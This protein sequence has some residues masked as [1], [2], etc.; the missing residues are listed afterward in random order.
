MATVSPCRT[1][2]V[3]ASVSVFTGQL[4]V[5][6]EHRC[7]SVI[8]GVAYSAARPLFRFGR[9]PFPHVT[10]NLIVAGESIS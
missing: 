4:V 10:A 6:L 2:S 8:R 9:L 7:S 5:D 1:A 3:V